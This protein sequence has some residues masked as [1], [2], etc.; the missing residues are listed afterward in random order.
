[1]VTLFLGCDLAYA[2]FKRGLTL[3]Q[4]SAGEL[5]SRFTG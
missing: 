5:M 4:F 2:T 3:T 1:M